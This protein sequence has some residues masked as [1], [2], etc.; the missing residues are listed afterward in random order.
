[1]PSAGFPQRRGLKL[2]VA[3]R[4]ALLRLKS[5]CWRSLPVGV[6]SGLHCLCRC[7][8]GQTAKPSHSLLAYYNAA[9][10]ASDP[11]NLPPIEMN[12]TDGGLVIPRDLRQILLVVYNTGFAHKM[13]KSVFY[14]LRYLHPTFILGFALA[15]TCAG[16]KKMTLTT[17]LYIHRVTE[18]PPQRAL[19]AALCCWPA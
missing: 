18:I 9:N 6:D 7:L 13:Q 19:Q 10:A 5:S 15:S 17:L 3:G 12:H 1:M 8:C 2:L 4:G 16:A 11:W 14:K